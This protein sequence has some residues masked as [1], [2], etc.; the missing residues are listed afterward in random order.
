MIA[1]IY[2]LKIILND[3]FYKRF[4]SLPIKIPI[5]TLKCLNLHIDFRNNKQIIFKSTNL[6]EREISFYSLKLNKCR[7]DT[8]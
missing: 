2:F 6:P 5:N 4:Y 7:I 3:V 8:Q 1:N